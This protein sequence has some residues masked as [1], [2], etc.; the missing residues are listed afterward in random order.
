VWR[1]LTPAQRKSLAGMWDIIK[2][3]QLLPRLM[4]S[5]GLVSGGSTQQQQHTVIEEIDDDADTAK[6]QQQQEQQQQ[7]HAGGA[8]NRFAV[9]GLALRNGFTQPALAEAP[10]GDDVMM[11][12]DQ[13]QQQQ[14]QQL[15]AYQ[16]QQLS[17][18]Q[19]H[20]QQQQL[21]DGVIRQPSV[22]DMEM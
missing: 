19:Q 4:P 3:E 5:S 6:Q 22:T 7:Q 9:D 2:T 20:Q 1:S 17:V 11:Q 15:L 16:Q 10:A 14:Q 18:Q 8:V 12:V 21:P 13:Q